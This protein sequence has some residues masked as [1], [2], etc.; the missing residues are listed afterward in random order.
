MLLHKAKITVQ[1]NG[2]VNIN[3]CLKYYSHQL[4]QQQIGFSNKS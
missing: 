4:K 1:L 3:K 2:G